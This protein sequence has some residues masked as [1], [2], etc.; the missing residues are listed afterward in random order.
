MIKNRDY[1]INTV[2]SWNGWDPLK[3]VVLGNCPDPEL[4]EDIKDHK[5]RD[6]LQKLLYETRED[7]DNLHKVLEDLGVDVVRLPAHAMSA[8]DLDSPIREYD[9]LEY[10]TDKKD[11]HSIKGL[12][13]PCLTPR[14]DF[15]VLGDKILVTTPFYDLNK[16][17]SIG[18][19]LIDPSCVDFRLP[20]MFTNTANTQELGPF[21]PSKEYSDNKFGL[22]SNGLSYTS[23]HEVDHTKYTHEK[24]YKRY[25]YH[26]HYFWAPTITRVGTKLIADL[27]DVSN[28]DTVLNDLYP[29]FQCDIT[30]IGGHNDGS[31]CLPKPGL[32]I[33]SPWVDPNQYKVT[34]PDWDILQIDISGRQQRAKEYKNWEHIKQKTRGAWWIPDADSNPE[35]VTFVE[36]WLTNWVGFCEETM[37]EVNMLSLDTK[38][39]L[40]MNYQKDVHSKLVQHG[41]EPI[42]VKFRHRNFWDGG[43]HCLT[44]DT[45]REGE[46]QNYFKEGSQ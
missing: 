38:T 19:Q 3:Q 31:Y 6:L 25:R 15:I 18:Q 12:P 30:S 42:Y 29:N 8:D 24:N 41:I 45:V 35:L 14:D 22:M 5:L 10:Y 32:V 17:W 2:N 43:L 21:I 20:D 7:L 34:L 16:K 37:F 46:Q 23:L 36:D 4:F 27:Q 11:G 39:I 13:K 28:L 9:S 26:T 1:K 40:S 44:L 33:C